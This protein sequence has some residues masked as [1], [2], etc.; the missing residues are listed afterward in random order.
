LRC[1]EG[2]IDPFVPAPAGKLPVT[3]GGYLWFLIRQ[4]PWPFVAMLVLGGATALVETG[5]YSFIGIIVDLLQTTPKE[6]L[7][8]QNWQL[9]AG[10]VFIV[11]VLRT[12]LAFFT[13]GVEEQTVVPGFYGRVR[14][15]AHQRIMEQSLA[16]FHD[17]FA[18]RISSKVWQAG[19]AAGEFMVTLLQVVWYI[20][21]YAIAT[22]LLLGELN[23]RLGVAI[24]VW[25]VIFSVIARY[26]VPRIRSSSR[27]A[28]HAA[29]G[30]TGRL[31]DTYS[32]IQTVK[33]FGSRESEQAG[34]RAIFESHLA[35]LM[36]FTRHLTEVRSLMSLLSSVMM[37]TI[38]WFALV[39]WQDGILTAGDVAV[40]L[41][42]A[43]R[44]NLLLGRMLSQLNSL[45]RSI[46]T[47]QDS[48]DMLM[49]P[50]AVND[51]PAAPALLVSKGEIVFDHVSFHYGKRG[52]VIEDLSFTVRGGEKIGIVGPSGAGKSTLAS[53]LLRFHDVESGR[54]LVD[55]QDIRRVTQESLRAQIGMVAQDTSLLHRSIRENIAYGRPDADLVML[56]DAAR[57]AHALDFIQSLKDGK[58]RSGF[59]AQVGERGVKLSGGQRQRIAIARALLKD[60]P[61]LVLD[62]ATSALDSEIEAAIQEN[63]T[64]LMQG[65]TVLAIAHRLSTIA[66]MDR[67]IVMDHGRIAEEGTHETLLARGGLYADLW[68]RQSGGFLPTGEDMTA[69]G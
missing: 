69:S 64:P 53:L 60:A 47:L 61:V 4:S 52:G 18:G 65:K 34:V 50:I 38:G 9:L 15:Q 1:L 39:L 45:F 62:E 13:A 27:A 63:L 58:G 57:Q 22:L 26:Y 31:V 49:R 20:V 35:V 8:A 23:W 67:L 55:G 12:V 46:G 68:E 17:E 43:L 36:R 14:W 59:D 16:F 40:A 11:L 28:A 42:L 2:W 51:E 5:L 54:I 37:V 29:S 25:L 10:M 19:Q 24:F 3:A 30:V 41:G 32:N 21:V 6:E 33:L 48:V 66:A 56:E 7:F 44:L